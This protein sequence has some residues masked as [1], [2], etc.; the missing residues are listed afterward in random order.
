MYKFLITIFLF[1]F[2]SQNSNGETL[3]RDAIKERLKQGYICAGI[4]GEAQFS[5]LLTTE[6]ITTHF[7]GMYHSKASD[8]TVSYTHLTLPTILLV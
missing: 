2:L 4:F 7:Y 6:I 5:D 1:I 3:D 8:I